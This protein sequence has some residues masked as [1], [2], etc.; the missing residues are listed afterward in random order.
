MIH[1]EIDDRYGGLSQAEINEAERLIDPEGVQKQQSINKKS[2]WRDVKKVIEAS[3]VVVYV[4]D[5][6]DPF[7]T[8]NADVEELI[9]EGKK[10]VVYA[11][12]KV[13][14]VPAENAL[15]WQARFKAEKLMCLPFQA[16]LANL[17][18]LNNK[19]QDEEKVKTDNGSEKMMSVLFKYA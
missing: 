6:R 3:D 10:K 13:D 17:T 5:A 2:H 15:A 16:N 18:I 8:R 11:L 12:N 1:Q 14:L 4:L 19:Q 9:Q 7:G